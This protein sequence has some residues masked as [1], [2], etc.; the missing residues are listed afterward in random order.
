VSSNAST[1]GAAHGND[2]S[3]GL[4]VA[5]RAYLYGIA[6]SYR[7][8]CPG[9][10]PVLDTTTRNLDLQIKEVGFIRHRLAA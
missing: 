1:V 9:I 6:L 8:H 7:L 5:A 4:P 10:S 2:R 3:R